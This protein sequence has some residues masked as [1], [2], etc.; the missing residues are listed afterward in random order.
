MEQ[1][2]QMTDL[3][4]LMLNR[5]Y[6]YIG[7]AKWYEIVTQVNINQYKSYTIDDLQCIMHSLH[8]HKTSFLILLLVRVSYDA[9]A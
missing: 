9:C 4:G 2:G 7:I 5:L 1:R 8:K 6:M 3:E